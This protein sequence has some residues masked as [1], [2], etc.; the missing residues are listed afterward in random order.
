[1]NNKNE[2]I[3]EPLYASNEQITKGFC[4]ESWFIIEVI[5]NKSPRLFYF[6]SSIDPLEFESFKEFIETNISVFNCPGDSSKPNKTI[7]DNYAS[8]S[9]YS[10]E[11]EEDFD[12]DSKK[13]F[14]VATGKA[15]I[16]EFHKGGFNKETILELIKNI[17]KDL[18]NLE[19]EGV[20]EASDYSEHNVG[21]NKYNKIKRN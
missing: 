2:I 6:N 18:T 20:F 16:M 17:N 8:I 15:A 5:S 11:L 13:T 9:S 3:I 12:E 1:M 7:R 4:E 14:M 10:G 19:S 21:R